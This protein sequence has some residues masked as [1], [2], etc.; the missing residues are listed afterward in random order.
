MKVQPKQ[1]ILGLGALFIGL[2]VWNNPQD[3]GDTT[4]DFV[5]NVW[6]WM[7]DAFDRAQEFSQSVVE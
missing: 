4:G 1:V 3:A 7:G 5:G 6:S 2:T